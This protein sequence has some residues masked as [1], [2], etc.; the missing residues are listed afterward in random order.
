LVEDKGI[1]R[2]KVCIEC[3]WVR[4]VRGGVWI[5]ARERVGMVFG[6]MEVHPLQI[7]CDGWEKKSDK[8]EEVVVWQR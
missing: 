3:K 1:S 7:G 6:V 5:C 4:Y 2:G 8:K